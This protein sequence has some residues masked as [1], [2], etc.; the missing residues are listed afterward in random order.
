MLGFDIQMNKIF[1]I[2]EAGVNH[3]GSVDIARK[4]IDVAV[5][6]GADAVK[7]QTFKAGRLVTKLAHKAKYQIENIA[8]QEESQYEMLKKLELNEREHKELIQYCERK[9]ILFLSTPFDED[10]ID[11]LDKLGI[12]IFKVPS[13]EITNLPYLRR[14]GSIGKQ[15]ILST[16]MSDLND[17]NRALTTLLESGATKD[18]ITLLHA[19]SEYPCPF[20]EVNL[21]AMQTIKDAFNVR[22]GYSDHSNGIHIPIAA[23][24]LGAC[25]I[26]KHFTL[27]KLMSGPDHKASLEPHELKDMVK[28]IRDIELAL[29]DGI[30]KATHSELKNI[31]VIRKSI[32]AARH[33]LAG[34]IFSEDNITIKRPGTGISPI[35]WD[36]VLGQK[37]KKDF[38]IDEL[39]VL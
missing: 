28:S 30:K 27:D 37:A 38:L 21:R 36:Y 11:M 12:S 8:I 32:V 10:S 24:A 13:G 22:V 23:A 1:I 5:D 25:V 19:T 33:I 31:A 4:L 29:G 2:A 3:N 14:L 17:I 34:E 6:S 9:K 39:I 16:G 7:F 15:L 20:Q 18:Q 26:E 35:M